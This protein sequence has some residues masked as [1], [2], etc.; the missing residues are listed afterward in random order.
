VI[1][2]PWIEGW[3][4]GLVG[5]LVF[6][7]KGRDVLLI[8]KKTGH[9]A[10]KINGPGGKL[11]DE[12]IT[13][14]AVREVR[15]ETGL[16][17]LDPVCLAELRFVE[18]DGPQW[19]GFAFKATRFEGRMVETREARPFW[20]SIDRIPYGD[21]WPD[22]EIWLPKVLAGDDPIVGDFLFN[23]GKLIDHEVRPLVGYSRAID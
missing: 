3:E 2:T 23:A 6:L 5:T 17:V 20:C 9:G 8:E 21:M 11:Q 13:E 7:V 12:T 14:C 1:D 18:R 10:G 15:E 22:D 4:P 16:T 19:L